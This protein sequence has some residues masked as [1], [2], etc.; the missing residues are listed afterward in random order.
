MITLKR[1]VF[2][3]Y[4]GSRGSTNHTPYTQYQ[5]FLVGVICRPS[6]K[7]GGKF[8]W[9]TRFSQKMPTKKGG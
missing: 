9:K 7:K 8:P 6:T 3:A 2:G 4:G 1:R 5:L